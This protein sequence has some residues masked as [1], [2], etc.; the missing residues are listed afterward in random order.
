MA[1]S[2]SPFRT[3]YVMVFGAL[4]VAL[5]YL[6]GRVIAGRLVGVLG[7]ALLAA[8]P[9]HIIVNSHI[10]W[11]NATTPFYATLTFLALTIYLKSEVGSRK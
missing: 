1:D 5:T 6:L 3:R 9:Q 7:A 8:A 11:Q 10:A 4:T 2:V